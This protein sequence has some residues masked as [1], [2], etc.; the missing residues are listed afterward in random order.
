MPTQNAPSEAAGAVHTVALAH[1]RRRRARLGALASALAA[2][3]LALAALI[4]WAFQA[5][6]R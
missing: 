1:M 6:R 4:A 5:C 2:A 3:L